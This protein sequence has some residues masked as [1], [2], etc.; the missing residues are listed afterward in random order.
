MI[1]KAVGTVSS[2]G[3][4]LRS[5]GYVGVRVLFTISALSYLKIHLL[6]WKMECTQ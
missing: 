5:N 3:A 6:L 2:S 1:A 4:K